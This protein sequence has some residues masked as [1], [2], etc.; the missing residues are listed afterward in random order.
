MR[1][2]ARI[3]AGLTVG[4]G[5][6]LAAS[7]QGPGFTCESDQACAGLRDG[8]C[9]PSGYCSVPDPDCEGS[10]R[11]YAPYSGELAEQCVGVEQAETETGTTAPGT[12][13]GP[14][15]PDDGGTTEPSDPS[16]EGS[17]STGI[18]PPRVACGGLLLIDEPFDALPLDEVLWDV[19]NTAGVAL[20]VIDGELRLTAV[21]AN[22]AYTG[23]YTGLPLPQLGSGGAELLAV[24]PSEVGAEAFVVLADDVSA[25]GFSVNG[26]LLH[27]FFDGVEFIDRSATK[28]DPIAHRWLRLRFD[29]F[30]R[31]LR[32]EV[33]PDG[34]DWTVIDEE[35][36]FDEG[37][38]F[39]LSQIELGAGVWDGPVSADPLGSFGHAF[40]CAE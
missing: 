16:T 26:G 18:E 4:V 22:N 14:P 36:E 15:T 17:D 25:Y 19:Y 32:W 38:S 9:E 39:F 35:Y 27:T 37:F 20:N 3:G 6:G 12:T 11:R 24:P 40:V 33:S 10:G 5:I 34:F 23:L 30:R 21:D 29:Q 8:Q 31:E 13:T 7:C 2:M 28:H 1:R